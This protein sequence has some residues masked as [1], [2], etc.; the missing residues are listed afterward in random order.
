MAAK[1]QHVG[2]QEVEQYC[3]EELEVERHLLVA[4]SRSTKH[5]KFGKHYNL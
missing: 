5:V 4:F 3:A 1:E 2:E